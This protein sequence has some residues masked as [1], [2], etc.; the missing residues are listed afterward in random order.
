[1][2]SFIPAQR[3]RTPSYSTAIANQGFLQNQADEINRKRRNAQ[4]KAPLDMYNTYVNLTDHN[5]VSDYLRGSGIGKNSASVQAANKTREL[6]QKLI[7]S[8]ID[9][10]GGAADAVTETAKSTVPDMAG[11]GVGAAGS[12]GTAAS[13]ANLAAALRGGNPAA[14]SSLPTGMAG[15]EAFQIAGAPGASTAVTEGAKAASL[16]SKVA[17]NAIPIAGGVLGAGANYMNEKSRGSDDWRVAAKTLG[18]AAPA[19]FLSTAPMLAAAGPVGW[20]G[21]AGLAAL[22]LYG[23]LG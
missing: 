8:Q 3:A 16:G 1:M 13:Q 20:A 7:Q 4:M 17:G 5:P 15:K 2:R 14:T 19:A 18:G 9:K 10:A 12:G 22:S 21:M 11:S 6:E 23:M